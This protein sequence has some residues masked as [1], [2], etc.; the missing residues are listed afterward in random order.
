MGRVRDGIRP[1]QSRLET[2][3]ERLRTRIGLRSVVVFGSR[4]RGDH[5]ENS[6]ID[7]LVIADDFRGMSSGQRI[8]LLLEAWSGIPALE[9]FGVTSEECTG[10]GWLLLWDALHQGRALEDDG[11]FKS[12]REILL[13]RIEEGNL[14]PTPGGWRERLGTGISNLAP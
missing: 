8:D 10:P 3:C 7:L 6:D 5:W 9:P 13:R 4:A 1:V 11:T 14:T 12:S 2:Y